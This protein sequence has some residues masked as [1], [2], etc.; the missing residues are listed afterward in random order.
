[1]NSASDLRSKGDYRTPVGFPRGKQPTRRSPT[2]LSEYTRD[3]RMADDSDQ[4][5]WWLQRISQW[6]SMGYETNAIE[7]NLRQNPSMGSEIVIM[8]EKNITI[9]EGLRTDITAMNERHAENAVSW[10]DMLDEPYNVEMVQEEYSRF[11]LRNRPWAI[12]AKLADRRWAE[13]GM[14]ERLEEMISRLDALDPVFIAK[15][16]LLGELFQEPR[17]HDKLSEE[18][19]R[20]E[21]SQSLRW[22]NLEKMVV[23]LHEKGVD[24][25]DVM[26][27]ELSDAYEKISRLEVLAEK[28]A[29][30]RND[31]TVGITPYDLGRAT[32]FEERLASLNIDNEEEMIAFSVEVNATSTELDVRHLKIVNRLRDLS[33]AGFIL[34]PEV[35]LNKK[36]LLP[37]EVMIDDLEERAVAHDKLVGEASTVAELWADLGEVLYDVGGDLTRTEVLKGALAESEERLKEIKIRAEEQVSNWSELGFEMSVWRNRF[38]N[39]PVEAMVKWQNHLP[40]LRSAL[41]LIRRVEELD[42]SLTGKEEVEGF[43]IELQASNIDSSLFEVV[44]DFLYSKGI[45]NKRHRR[46]LENDVKELVA[47]GQ[48]QEIALDGEM[49]LKGLEEL[50]HSATMGVGLSTTAKE[51]KAERLPITALQNELNS[52][53]AMNWDVSGLVRL[54]ETEPLT[55]GRMIETIRA[56]MAGISDLTRRLE[57]LPLQ[58]APNTKNEIERMMRKPELISALRSSIPDFAARAAM[59]AG[60]ERGG[61]SLWKPE[62]ME[63]DDIVVS[64]LDDMDVEVLHASIE[65]MYSFGM[66]DDIGVTE[67]TT[68]LVKPVIPSTEPVILPAETV[69]EAIQEPSPSSA[70]E[71]WTPEENDIMAEEPEFDEPR[72]DVE[73]MEDPMVDTHDGDVDEYENNLEQSG[74]FETLRVPLNRL[75]ISLGVLGLKDVLESEEI[76]RIRFALASKVGIKPRDSRVD[77]LLKLT[78]R[79]IPREASEDLRKRAGMISML[80]G[81]ADNLNEWAA[82][83]L[84]S[85]NDKVD[86]GLLQNSWNLGK[87]LKRIPGPGAAL[88]LEPDDYQLPAADKLTELATEVAKLCNYSNL[89]GTTGIK[90]L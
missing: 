20:L 77:R 12:D 8:I 61:V 66:E 3:S 24:A 90:A 13:L 27:L 68:P 53:K 62:R 81:C 48:L 38:L 45:R 43:I 6:S 73:M 10:L 86:E 83:R 70:P 16:S 56:D 87:A 28:F 84:R 59:E 22:D 47:K 40:I 42:T 30:I 7:E 55:L 60:G 18:I 67:S 17:L 36:A 85:R 75:L 41:D 35:S 80:A 58:T 51:R 34:P 9:A 32:S 26:S 89:G 2:Q 76:D 88:P 23:S 5:E 71:E 54:L 19:E 14:L 79:L 78:L 72:T 33:N 50:V 11:N 49:K 82:L 64:E 39:S 74:D 63:S 52:W 1:M 15:G 25:E 4:P 21:V 57:R 37:M 69:V 31:I 65:E 29:T 44:E 46:L